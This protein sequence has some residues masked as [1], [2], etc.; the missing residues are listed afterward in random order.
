MI[1]KSFACRIVNIFLSISFNIIKIVLGAQK[2]LLIETVLLS[3]N[4]IQMFKLR[5]MK[6]AF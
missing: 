4:P 2:N 1:K 5:N 6:V 3:S